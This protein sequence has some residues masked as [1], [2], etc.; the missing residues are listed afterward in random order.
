M[1]GGDDINL[2]L[3]VNLGLDKSIQDAS[4]LANQI[5]DM[6]QDQEAFVNSV[7]DSQEKL[8]LITTELQKQLDFKQQMITAENELRGIQE[9]QK[10]N[11]QD[12]LSSY[13][14]LNNVVNNL[15]LNM[16]RINGTP[17][18]INNMGGTGGIGMGQDQGQPVQQQQ[19]YGPNGQAINQGGNRNGGGRRDRD[20]DLRELPDEES[21]DRR[22]SKIDE[23]TY[24]DNAR[25]LMDKGILMSSSDYRR[26]TGPNDPIPSR[27]GPVEEEMDNPE[28]QSFEQTADLSRLLPSYGAGARY[29]RML[30]YYTS[31]GIGK[32][33]INNQLAAG[34]SGE[35]IIGG[36]AKMGGYNPE[37][38]SMGGMMK[39]LGK[40]GAVGSLALQG[41][42][43]VYGTIA[44]AL[45]EGQLY[46]GL[47]GG[48]GVQGALGQDLGAQLTSA[49][50][51][52]P[53]ESYGTAK[54]IR[55]DALAMGY[56]QNSA[57]EG[58]AVSF[59]NYAAQKFGMD[60]SKSMEMFNIA[61]V[62]AGAS[63][64]QLQA[65]LDGL[66]RQSSGTQL[67]FQQAQQTF[68]Q[69]TQNL[70]GIGITGG[71]N[72]ALSQASAT[73][74]G[75]NLALQQSGFN[76]AGMLSSTIG[77]AMLAQEMGTTVPMLGAATAGQSSRSM[78][79]FITS[80][81]KQFLGMCGLNES[82]YK[83]IVNGQYYALGQPWFIAKQIG[84]GL[85]L[86]IPQTPEGWMGEVTKTFDGTFEKQTQQA[87]ND[88][89]RQ[90]ANTG[91]EPGINLD[92][93]KYNKATHQYDFTTNLGSGNAAL[94]QL[95]YVDP[96]GE[97]SMI[98][99]L[100]EIQSRNHWKDIGILKDGKFIDL[101]TIQ[102]WSKEKQQQTFD[103]IAVG[104]YQIGESAEQISKHNLKVGDPN[105]STYLDLQHAADA[106][107]SNYGTTQQQDQ[108]VQ[109]ISA[110]QQIA[111]DAI[112]MNNNQ[113][114]FLGSHSQQLH[115]IEIGPNAKQ[116]FTLISDPQKFSN[117][118]NQWMKQQGS[119][120]SIPGGR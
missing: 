112:S 19:L 35:G 26:S 9:S 17:I 85:G 28:V 59:G 81:N 118:L 51:L 86:T 31:M 1:G 10:Q 54:Q 74:A 83:S 99:K 77:Q 93:T 43:A 16:S 22:T 75:G 5:R 20:I 27:D 4:T 53:F 21:Q 79:G 6:R 18:D 30:K 114:D 102:S 82:N 69:T 50:G 88:Q 36:I 37:T 38:A 39:G 67:S 68:M 116:F 3:N 34:M 47:T 56:G 119:P 13:R 80:I 46:T 71:A 110:N 90:A 58:Q 2:G 113:K 61:V 98:S 108:A 87:N 91:S 40:A 52:N 29:S 62:Q 103:M 42:E 70:A 109:L 63:A 57:L 48:T 73:F 105:G 84:P 33:L 66:A 64:T 14:E 100:K 101:K 7:A 32:D 117:W 15:A 44:G 11:A 95:A 25:I 106:Q 97:S 107:K 65:S 49:F 111:R 60:P 115:Q 45:Q 89:V 76:P 41:A 55:M 23:E 72:L 24:K 104:E 8:T 94:S 92:N 120:P 12:M 78:A 96:A